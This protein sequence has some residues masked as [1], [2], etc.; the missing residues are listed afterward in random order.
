MKKRSN[1][2]LV[3]ENIFE[4]D[5]TWFFTFWYWADIIVILTPVCTVT[6]YRII[7]KNKQKFREYFQKRLDMIFCIKVFCR[8]HVGITTLL[9]RDVV[10][11]WGQFRV[12]INPI[13]TRGKLCP[14]YYFSP[15][16]FENLTTCAPTPPSPQKIRYF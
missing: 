10:I 13:L 16:G 1:M 2:Y 8:S 9:L 15:P 6:I 5:E 3:T 12:S 11:G 7:K 14:P 4:K